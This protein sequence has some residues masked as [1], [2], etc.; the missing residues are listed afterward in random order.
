MISRHLTVHHAIDLYLLMLMMHQ[1]LRN[2]SFITPIE[3]TTTLVL[4]VY[5]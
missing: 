4:S 5:F 2:T 1:K 3:N